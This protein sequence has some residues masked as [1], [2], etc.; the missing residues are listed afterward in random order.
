VVGGS[1]GI[2]LETARAPALRPQTSSSPAGIP[3]GSK[4]GR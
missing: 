2:G 1:S 4:S 3:T